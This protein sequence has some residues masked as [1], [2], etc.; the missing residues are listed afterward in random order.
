MDF[1]QFANKRYKFGIVGLGLIG[2]SLAK[3]LREAFNSSVIVAFNRRE[4]PRKMAYEEK[5]ADIVT[6]QIDDSFRDCDYIYLCTPVEYNEDYLKKLI[7]YIGEKTI[8]TDV[9]STKTSIHKE[10][11]KLGIEAHFIGGHPMA[12]S[13]KTGYEFSNLWLFKNAYYAI[14]PTDKTDSNRLE[15]FKYIAKMIGAKPVVLDYEEH[16]Y[17]VAGISHLP[18]LVASAMTNLV[19]EKDSKNQMMHKLAANGFKDST[20][21]AASS[22]EMWEQICMTNT[23]NIVGLVDDYIAKL[24]ELSSHLKEKDGEYIHKMFEKSRE[25]RETF[26]NRLSGN[27]NDL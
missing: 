8:I 11:E 9:G 13:E 26:G 15:E 4:E 20:R 7:P 18:H 5:V 19:Q 6:G 1:N 3:A 10:V 22:P 2:G 25:Y 16:D 23:E 14:T 21:I 12:G 24:Q 27:P 17:A